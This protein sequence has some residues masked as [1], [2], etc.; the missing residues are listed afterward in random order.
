MLK[1]G[2][3][4][5]LELDVE[6]DENVAAKLWDTE[7]VTL[8]DT[9]PVTLELALCVTAP[10]TLELTLCVTAPVTLELTLCDTAPVTLELTLELSLR[11][12]AP[13]TLEL[14][15]C[16]TE[17]VTLELSLRDTAPVT[18]WDRVNDADAL[19]LRLVVCVGKTEELNV[20]NDVGDKVMDS[21]AVREAVM[22]VV[23]EGEAE[24]VA[25]IEGVEAAVGERERLWLWLKVEDPDPDTV[26]IEDM[27]MELLSDMETLDDEEG[28]RLGD[29][30]EVEEELEDVV[31]DTLVL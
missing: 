24:A 12:T 30:L 3:P 28:V 4:D 22:A 1:L 27:V 14:T 25:L 13:V 10:V 2:D 31:A 29:T 8:W 23:R 7:D 5:T 16:D 26:A 9:D 6:T 21:D 20:A 17:A 11:D 15:L 19:V 18:L